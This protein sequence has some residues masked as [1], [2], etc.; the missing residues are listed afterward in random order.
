M[1]SILMFVLSSTTLGETVDL[2][3]YDGLV[4]AQAGPNC[5]GT[6]LKLA[7][8]YPTFRGVDANEFQAFL[9]LACTATESPKRG[10]LGV[11]ETP[12]FGA[13]HAFIYLDE[14]VGMDKPGVDYMGRTPVSVRSHEV[15]DYH[16]L[17]PQECRRYSPDDLS[18]CAN[19][20]VFYSCD[21]SSAIDHF[22]DYLLDVRKFERKIAA[23]LLKE[24]VSLRQKETLREELE[25]LRNKLEKLVAEH[26]PEQENGVSSKEISYLNFQIESLADQI[27]FF[28]E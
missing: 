3:E 27:T 23:L 25:G 2:E 17:A 24:R 22:T 12:G 13:V 18:L 19:R 4:F 8:H 5:F 20:K 11:Y 9:D 21:S 14:E 10:D 15:I 28:T 1:I 26:S 16:F 7:G 6:A